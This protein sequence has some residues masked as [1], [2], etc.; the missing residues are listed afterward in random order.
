MITDVNWKDKFPKKNRY[1]ET[2][3]GILYCGDCLEIL[4]LFSKESVNLVLTDPP[5]GYKNVD[6]KI[7]VFY[8]NEKEFLNFYK[9]FLN[10]SFYV[11][12]R[13][14]I[15]SLFCNYKM[16]Y[17]IRLLL[18]NIFGDNNFVNELI[19]CYKAGN[20][21]K[22]RPFAQKHDTIYIY[23]KTQKFY[24]KL[25]K[26]KKTGSRLKSWLVIESIA[27]KSGFFKKDDE[28][29]SLTP[30]Q[31]PVELFTVLLEALSKKLDVVLDPFIGSGTTA[32][33]C[34]KLNRRW[35]GIEINPEYCEVMKR[36]VNDYLV[37]NMYLGNHKYYD[38]KRLKKT[39]LF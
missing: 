24:F 4:S 11:L 22:N 23:S 5:Y 33:V 7:Q 26:D 30:Y 35:I 38:K 13:N 15:I 12:K 29:R 6:R 2:E 19:W 17:K 3:N 10:Y 25:L 9:V 8:K 31:K 28:W 21:S 16:N 1:F 36:R 32:I 18:D 14:G 27:D 37:R 20:S 34:E 39:N